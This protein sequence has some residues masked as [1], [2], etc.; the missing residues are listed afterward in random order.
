MT[1]TTCPVCDTVGS[2]TDSRV[3]GTRVWRC[4]NCTVTVTPT[5]GEDAAKIDH[6][7]SKYS[8]VQ[9]SPFLTEHHRYFRYPEFAV[10]LRKISTYKSPPAT[11]LDVGC[12]HGFFIDAARR[13]G[14][15]VKGV[16]P[17]D[18]ARNY[19]LNIGLNVVEDIDLIQSKFDVVSLWHVLEHIPNPREFV[20]KL[21]DKLMTGGLLCI[22][23]P[24]FNCLSR[25]ILQDKWIW[26]LPFLHAVH[27]NI[28]ALV[29]LLEQ[30]DFT[31]EHAARQ[32]PNSL[33]TRRS[34][35]LSNRVFR[36]DLQPENYGISAKI[37]RLGADITSQELFVIARKK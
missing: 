1:E 31:I 9:E 12:D 28:E 36:K 37:R 25:R 10:L 27:Y 11:W 3:G 30:L 19:A 5:D 13:I 16:E 7:K 34:Y 33:V 15:S 20:Q 26:F 29:T 17:S 24:D 23:V 4:T 14:Y 35:R 21:S 18:R 2:L 32:R 22:R 6:Y 8:L